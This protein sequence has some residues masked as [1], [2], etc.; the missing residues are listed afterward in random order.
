VEWFAV[1]CLTGRLE[2]DFLCRTFWIAVFFGG[3]YDFR[4][5]QGPANKAISMRKLKR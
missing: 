1:M 4:C 3:D 2:T 5:L